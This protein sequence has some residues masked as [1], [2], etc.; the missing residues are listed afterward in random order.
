[1]KRLQGRPRTLESYEGGAIPGAVWLVDMGD[2]DQPMF[3]AASCDRLFD[4]FAAGT[5]LRERAAK[6]PG[7]LF[8]PD[9][10]GQR[11]PARRK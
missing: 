3:A 4:I 8:S 10:G 6:D 7:Y 2:A 1:M 9:L 11:H 5:D